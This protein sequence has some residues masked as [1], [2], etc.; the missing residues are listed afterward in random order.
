MLSITLQQMRTGWVRLIAA[1]L[2]IMLGTGFVAAAMIGGEVMKSAAYQ[3]F[4]SDYAGADVVVS[5][6]FYSDRP[7]D[8]TAEVVREVASTEGV[9]AVANK[10]L[11]DGVAEAGSGSEWTLL[12][13]VDGDSPGSLAE[14]AL[15][16]AAG[17]A[18][19][20]GDIARRLSLEVGDEVSIT[21]FA[22]DPEADESDL[23]LTYTITG[24]LTPAPNIFAMAPDAL[25]TADEFATPELRFATMRG[26]LAL[27][28]DA[29]ADPDTVMR[30]LRGALGDSYQVATVTQMAENTMEEITGSVNAM[31]TLLFG[32]AG[33]ALAVAALVIGNTFSVLVAQRTRHLA[34]LR[35]VGASRGQVRRSVLLEA[36]ILGAVASAAGVLFGFAVI[37]GAIAL[38][39]S[40]LPG[41]NLWEGLA[42]NPPIWVTTIL[43]GLVL[44]LLA[45]W[46]PARAATKV[47]PLEALRPEP[48]RLGTTAG[49]LRAAVSALAF[50]GGAALLAAGVM[51]GGGPD[52][53]GLAVMLGILGGF[54]SVLGVVLGA[55]FVI[56][57]VVRVVG[58]LFGRG[59]PATVAVAGA[60]RNPRR[61][62]TTANALFIGVGLV[63][64]VG[65][66]AV[67]AKAALD[68]ELAETFPIDM[69]VSSV[70]ADASAISQEQ[71]DAVSALPEV[72]A[73]AP[74]AH[75]YLDLGDGDVL[76]LFAPTSTRAGSGTQG[77][78]AILADPLAFD[79]L[80][81]GEVLGPTWLA[82]ARGISEG[83][84]I[85][86]T[87]SGG[88]PVTLRV[89]GIRDLPGGVL[90][91]E[92]T[93]LRVDSQ[94]RES[95]LW[96]ELAPGADAAQALEGVTD[97][98]NSAAGPVVSVHSSALERDSFASV[99]DTLLFIVSAMLAVAVVIA[100]VGV[101]NTLSLSVL[102]RRRESAT[103]RALGL[104]TGQLRGMLAIEGVIIA[105][106]GT[107]GGVIGGL[108]YGWAGAATMLASFASVTPVVPW[109]MILTAIA[110][111]V[112]S[113]LLAS[114]LPAH[115]AVKVSP[116][117]ALAEE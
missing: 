17:D 47:R 48:L 110:V 102:E 54:A 115:T 82:D 88:D 15:P 23:R 93:L 44:T 14:G 53:M 61:T 62:A 104:T 49:R 3:S 4:T 112:A 96:I 29:A 35:T 69:E 111:A 16:T 27:K 63:V 12:G 67:T 100:L 71:V 84:T 6:D 18:A 13:A 21:V 95:L 26:P 46:A 81:D 87:S 74:V 11:I 78:G 85:T 41:I 106:A 56:T 94:A 99:I 24:L 36:L 59:V 90:T 39:S 31:R 28:L 92:E 89:V 116:V 76:D 68:N 77:P 30:E 86:G 58:K 9:T 34:L 40:R 42:L 103:L 52:R 5:A 66:G 50:F 57:P 97:A 65:T 51:L 72:G 64:M 80:E 10:T 19:L 83:E 107:L 114:V 75:G 2:A 105:L 43:A 109:G 101:A 1:G 91:T 8:F 37:A 117:A 38:L 73:V 7:A 55:A 70:D 32:F 108:I 98:L 33:V 22:G 25:I 60:L 79:S 45:G 20:A 113:G